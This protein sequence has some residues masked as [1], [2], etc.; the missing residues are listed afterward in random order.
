MHKY[1]R[2][3]FLIEYKYFGQ[4]YLFEIKK[5]R[6]LNVSQNIPLIQEGN[7]QKIGCISKSL[8]SYSMRS[9]VKISTKI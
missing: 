4:N 7:K 5:G 8:H 9:S 1:Y 2:L 3:G 6:N